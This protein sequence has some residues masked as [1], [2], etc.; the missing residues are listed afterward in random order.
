MGRDEKLS[1]VDFLRDIRYVVTSP[2][3]RFAVIQ[4]RGSAWGSLLLL[5]VPS[6]FAFYYFG[7]VMFKRD[8][9]PG[10]SFLPP[11]AIAVAAVYCKLYLIHWVARR[12]L[13]KGGSEPD[14]ATFSQLKTVFGYTGVPSLL[15]ALIA[16]ALFI[17]MPEG[18]G[19]AMH[20]FE[21]VSVSIMV[22]LGI[23]LF[24][25]NLILV[26]LALRTVYSMRDLKLVA[27]F[28]LGSILMAVPALC[29]LWIAA[30][31]SIEF[32]YVQPILS[33]RILH[34]LALDPTT[35]ISGNTKISIH[36]DRLVY[37]FT[38]PDHFDL[39][40]Y[41][42]KHPQ[43]TK[44]V[45]E[46]VEVG[47]TSFFSWDERDCLLGRVVG[48]PG[49]S[50]ELIKGNLYINN[51]PW[52]ERYLLPAFRSDA[53]LP[54]IALGP[55]QYCILPEDRRLIDTLRDEIIVDRSQIRGREIITRWPLGWWSFQP[56][57]FLQAQ[58]SK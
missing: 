18:L 24:I 40:A 39:V 43:P 6:Y 22:G 1:F 25:W 47:S 4:E 30:P 27:S 23:A 10:Y 19:Y 53:D 29:T 14:R 55:S 26:V 51:Q 16:I 50:V 57:I 45:P 49:D 54:L 37:H 21:V 3:R 32:T 12:F 38:S 48:R 36:F 11:L 52:D 46:T 56:S 34:F 2:A 31:A 28:I 42:R 41:R 9:F 7:G 5:I 8:P 33:N 35:S 17:T 20:S 15:A 58:P 13:G 44:H